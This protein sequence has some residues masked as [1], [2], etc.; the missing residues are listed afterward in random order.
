MANAVAVQRDGK[1]VLA[2]S[3]DFH[4]LCDDMGNSCDT[5]AL[6]RLNDDGSLDRTFGGSGKVETRFATRKE[7][8]SSVVEGIVIQRD[9]RIVAAGLGNGYDFALARYTTRGT[10]DRTFGRSGKEL[11]DFGSG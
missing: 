4:G 1:V 11:T 9:G 2:G 6:V 3:S 7:R 8:S 10:L 5:F